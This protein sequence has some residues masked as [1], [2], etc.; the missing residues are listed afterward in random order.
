M[1]LHCITR[2]VV[3]KGVKKLRTTGQIPAELFGNHIENR[4]LSIDVKE[5]ARINKLAGTHGIV[6]LIIDKEAPINVLITDVI[7][8]PYVRMPLSIGLHAVRMD[9]KIHTYIP[10][11]YKGESPA[12]K[13]GLPIIKLIDEVEIEALPKNVPESIIVQL[14]TLT[15]E[16]PKIHIKDLSVPKNV[17]ILHA[18]PEQVV[19]TIGEK[20]EEETK[21]TIQETVKEEVTNQPE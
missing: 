8:N 18:D 9:E 3:G 6:E 21:E 16:A 15:E 13:N 7:E 20:T 19:V 11:V 10:I 2:T 12:T 5:F 14:S 1:K 4:H 17:K